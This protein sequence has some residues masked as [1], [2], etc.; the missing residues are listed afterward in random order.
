MKV[1]IV[2]SRSCENLPL[3]TIINNIPSGC[4]E[5]VSGGA[6]GIDRL[7]ELAAARLDIQ[8][9]IFL[10]DYA[11]YFKSAPLIRNLEIIDYSDYVLAF[12]DFKSIGT[13]FIINN[14]INK[15]KKVKIID[16]RKS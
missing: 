5:I 6:C 7:A 1:A 14:C 3:Q 11:K 2:G 9:K 15:S 8:I 12:W 13:K 10:P 16:I 4:S